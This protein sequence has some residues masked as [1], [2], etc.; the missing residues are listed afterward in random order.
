MINKTSKCTGQIVVGYVPSLDRTVIYNETEKEIAICG[1]YFGEPDD[2]L[3]AEFADTG[4]VA[5]L[6]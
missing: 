3:T 2:E 6:M 5:I 4:C 1:W